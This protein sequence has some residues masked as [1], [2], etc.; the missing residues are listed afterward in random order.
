MI[1][2]INENDI[3]QVVLLLKQLDASNDVK[4]FHLLK[5][6]IN[7]IQ[8][9]EHIKIVGFELDSKIIGMYTISII[10]GIT[11][12]FKSFA[13]I[14]NV[15]VDVHYRNRELGKQLMAHAIETAQKENCYK[16]IL[17]TGTKQEWKIKFYEKCGFSYGE[18]TAFI[19]K[20]N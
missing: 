10:D 4:D 7:S 17:E 12:A 8:R 20:F 3:E 5:E 18:K 9:K 6:K 13:I 14:E 15:V 16:V 2:L 19:K 1:R 11:H